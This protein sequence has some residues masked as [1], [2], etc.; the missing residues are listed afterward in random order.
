M[1]VHLSLTRFSSGASSAL[2]F[3]QRCIGAMLQDE[4]ACL[5]VAQQL[6]AVEKAVANAKKAWMHDHIAPCGE[7]AVHDKS[8]GSGEGVCQFKEITT[9]LRDGAM[10]DFASLIEPSAP[11]VPSAWLFMPGAVLPRGVQEFERARRFR[12]LMK[13]GIEFLR[14]IGVPAVLIGLA[15]TVSHATVAGSRGLAGLPGARQSIGASSEPWFQ[16]TGTLLLGGVALWMMVWGWS[17]VQR[18]FVERGHTAKRA[19]DSRSK[20]DPPH[21]AQDEENRRLETGHGTVRL[22]IFKNIDGARFRLIRDAAEGPEWTA[23]RVQLE[24]ERLDGST[25]AFTFLQRDGF[26]ESAHPVPE[27]HEFIAHLHL[28]HDH[29]SH[30][31]DIRFV[32]QGTVGY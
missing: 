22:E 1:T 14:D 26:V 13:T 24:T 15:S 17:S 16:W 10:T 2:K 7:R 23:D 3:S 32:T 20:H 31:F 8:N 5:E 19:G 4:R 6:Q 25:Q 18:R 27:P 28:Q 9:Y 12:T 11:S 29:H 21:S 30:D